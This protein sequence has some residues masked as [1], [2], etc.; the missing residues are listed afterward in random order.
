MLLYC[1]V[2]SA[3]LNVFANH[4]KEIDSTRFT[5]IEN[6]AKSKWNTASDVNLIEFEINKQSEGYVNVMKLLNEHWG[7]QKNKTIIAMEMLKHSNDPD[8]FSDANWWVIHIE[9][10]NRLE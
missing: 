1:T 7:C 2:A 4:I 5:M 8:Y 9:I 6:Y 10:R 3:Q